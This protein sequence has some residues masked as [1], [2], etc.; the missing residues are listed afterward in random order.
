MATNAAALEA[1]LKVSIKAAMTAA[2][3]PCDF[4]MAGGWVDCAVDALAAGIANGL[5]PQLQLL[6]DLA[7]TPPSVGHV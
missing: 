1:A 7:G 4:N 3:P 5:Y 2:A 6:D